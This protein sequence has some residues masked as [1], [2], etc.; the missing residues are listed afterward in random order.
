M[1][2]LNSDHQVVVSHTLNGVRLTLQADAS[3]G[4]F[5]NLAA[6]SSIFPIALSASDRS[7]WLVQACVAALEKA[8]HQFE[9]SLHQSWRERAEEE[10][11][12]AQ[13]TAGGAA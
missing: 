5:E 3:A 12:N 1:Q 13:S 9:Q 8:Q 11:A 10:L 7:T 4:S 6:N 2:S